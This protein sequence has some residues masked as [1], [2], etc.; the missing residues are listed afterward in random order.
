MEAVVAMHD[1]MITVLRDHVRQSGVW[2]GVRR[3][4]RPCTVGQSFDGA[5]DGPPVEEGSKEKNDSPLMAGVKLLARLSAA[6]P[7]SSNAPD[8]FMSVAK[9]P[10][11]GVRYYSNT[12][13]TP[14]A[15]TR[16]LP[17]AVGMTTRIS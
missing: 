2:E 9:P 7:T 16:S 6:S 10:G 12:I 5:D 1:N 4:A 17:V 11:H 8:G 13:S 14:G 15:K 3:W